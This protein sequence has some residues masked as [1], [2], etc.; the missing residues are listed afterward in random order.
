[1]SAC[2]DDGAPTP[3]RARRRRLLRRLAAAVGVWLLLAAVGAALLLHPRLAAPFLRFEDLKP[4]SDAAPTT[5]TDLSVTTADGFVIRGTILAPPSP[6]GVV[7]LW[8]G[9][10]GTRLLGAAAHVASW[11]YEAVACD[12][13]GHGASDGP[14]TTFGRDEA[15][16]VVAVAA[17]ARTRRPGLPLAAWGISLGGA[18][19][20][21]AAE[22]SRDFDAVILESVYSTL[23]S[24]FDRRFA[25]FAPAW[26]APLAAPA[27]TF[28]VAWGRLD[29]ANV[30]PPEAARR[31]RPERTLLVTGAEDPWATT[32]DL[33][34]LSES[35]PGAPTIVVPGARHHDLRQVG[36]ADY[37]ARVRAFLDARMT[38]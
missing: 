27:W 5:R 9:Y 25:S 24:S 20:A 15:R 4:P 23:E 2:C 18:A 28:A 29:P 3:A 30:R 12:F 35:L 6:K 31:L 19:I 38:R 21:F 26:L 37:L 33:R 16:D 13:R 8:H 11:G 14:T 22:T 32:D 10:G 34:L 7:L 1:M 36:G 17:D